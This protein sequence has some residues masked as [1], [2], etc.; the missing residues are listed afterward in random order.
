MLNTVMLECFFSIGCD[1]FLS[2]DYAVGS[3][4]TPEC[5]AYAGGNHHFTS[6]V[7][8]LVQYSSN[9]ASTTASYLVAKKKTASYLASYSDSD[10]KKVRE[11]SHWRRTNS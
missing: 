3:L 11:S 1:S 7:L 9:R 2:L 8:L 10:K 5:A 4:R 6:M